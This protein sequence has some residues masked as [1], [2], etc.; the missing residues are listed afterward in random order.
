MH[1][2]V[3][4]ESKQFTGEIKIAELIEKEGLSDQLC[5]VAVNGVFVPKPKHDDMQLHEGDVVEIVSPREG[6]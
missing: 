4:D 6:G 3:N 1:I 2:I 5:A